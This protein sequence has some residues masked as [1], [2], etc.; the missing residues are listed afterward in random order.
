MTQSSSPPAAALRPGKFVD[1]DHPDV[2][3]FARRTS[4]GATTDHER[5]A[6][7]FRAVREHPRYDPYTLSS[8]PDD[9]KASSVLHRDGAYCIPK[10]V[11]LC[12]AA[13]AL[14]IP[15]RLGFA[16][17]KNHLASPKLLA[18][19]GSDLFIFHGYVEMWLDGHPIKATPA[20]NAALCARFGVPALE[21]LPGQ[22]AL[23]QA[24]DGQG[25]LHMEYVRQRGLYDD[26]PLDEILTEFDALYGPG[27]I[28]KG[29][30]S[31]RSIHDEAFH[32]P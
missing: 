9:Y 16:D 25:R 27:R 4:E 30:D 31:L 6:L 20:F 14:G 19:L 21:L 24:F 23:L 8:N 5:A 2:V 26:L 22:D 28:P 32:G 17:V 12:A 10:A 3:A 1:S 18:M 7:L 15:A 29:T 11:L 13:R